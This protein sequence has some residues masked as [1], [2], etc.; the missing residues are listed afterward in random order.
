MLLSGHAGQR[1]EPVGVMGSALFD[2]PFL[3]L[4]GNDV[5]RRQVKL[6]ALLDGLFQL[7]VHLLRQ[8]LLHHRVVEYVGTKDFSYI[9]K[10]THNRLHLSA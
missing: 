5:C 7:L 9:R 3:H 2:G 4:M 1:L 6:L 8:T 10:F